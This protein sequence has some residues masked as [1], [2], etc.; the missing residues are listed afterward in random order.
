MSFIKITLD[1]EELVNCDYC[2]IVDRKSEMNEYRDFHFICNNCANEER[3][4]FL[5]REE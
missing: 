2:N 1:K 5:G 4:F 3:D